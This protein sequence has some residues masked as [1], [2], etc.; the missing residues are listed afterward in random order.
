MFRTIFTTLRALLKSGLCAPC[1]FLAIIKERVGGGIPQPCNFPL[2]WPRLSKT[3]WMILAPPNPNFQKKRHP[4]PLI[5]L[6]GITTSL[7]NV[8]KKVTNI[9]IY[10]SQVICSIENLV[11]SCTIFLWALKLLFVVVVITACTLSIFKVTR[12]TF[13]AFSL[14]I[15]CHRQCKETLLDHFG[16]LTSL[17]CLAIFGPSPVMNG[18]PQSKKR[19]IITSPMC[20][21]LV[22][23][24]FTPFGT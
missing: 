5:Y 24:Q 10:L 7:Y 6:W 18:R 4:H 13:S 1:L 22:E 16:A 8:I 12:K 19:L 23:P 17:P 14:W 15:F 9:S 3:H 21:L 11:F 20:G 2:K